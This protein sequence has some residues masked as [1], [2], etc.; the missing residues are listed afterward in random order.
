M[1][2]VLGLLLLPGLAHSEDEINVAGGAAVQG[3]DV[4]SYFTEG[5]PVQGD[6]EFTASYNGA[7]YHFSSVAN[8][9]LFAA[10]PAAYAPQYGGYCAF[11]AAMGR[12]FEIDPNAFSVVDDKLYLN[13][14]KKVQKRWLGDV[15]GF[16]K[17]ADN[18]WSIIESI[19][20]ASLASNTPEGVTIGAQ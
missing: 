20:D 19:A 3:F 1:G 4:V 14:S 13:N 11:G 7:E 9:D 12:K 5:A 10:D 16:I 8:R 2:G 15:P 17:G 6:A 18:N